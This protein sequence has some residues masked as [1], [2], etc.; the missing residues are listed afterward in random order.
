MTSTFFGRKPLLA[1]DYLNAPS[2]GNKRNK[3]QNDKNKEQDLGDRRRA[4]CDAKESEDAGNDG[5]D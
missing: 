3:E 1:S 2:S 4:S 5:D